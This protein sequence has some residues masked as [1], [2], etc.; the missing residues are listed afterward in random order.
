MLLLWVLVFTLIGIMTQRSLV[1]GSVD[2]AAYYRAAARLLNGQALYSDFLAPAPYLYPPLLAQLLTPLAASMAVLPAAQVWYGINVGLAFVTVA[3][4]ATCVPARWRPVLWL[5]P[6][7][8]SPLLLSHVFGQVNVLLFALLTGTWIAVRREQRLWGGAMLATAAWL[9]VFP[10]LLVVYFLWKRDWRVIV[11]VVIAGLTL[12]LVQLVGVG[13]SNFAAYFTDV[14]PSL[15]RHG[16]ITVGNHSAVGTAALLFRDFPETI[17]LAENETLF[18]LTYY[19]VVAGLWG[20]SGW[21]ISRPAALIRT[22]PAGFDLEYGLVL[23]AALLS[24]STL[25]L[26]GLP[27]ILLVYVL[28]LLN[29]PPRHGRAARLVSALTAAVTSAHV[30]VRMADL[31]AA[32]PASGLL[33]TGPFWS[34]LLLWGTLVIFRRAAARNQ[35]A[36]A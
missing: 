5:T 35:P 14:L 30:L 22:T 16:Q 20:V 34:L 1:G 12:L 21:A 9:K 32:T 31:S 25:W 2:F 10:A 6:L 8:Y 17:P 23:V 19:G 27:P 29:A 24:G 3:A 26:R 33:F 28:L 13:A 15:A 4:L 11:G 18:R 7:V 36:T